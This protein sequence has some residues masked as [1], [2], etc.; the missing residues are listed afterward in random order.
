MPGDHFFFFFNI[1]VLDFCDRHTVLILINVPAPINVL[2]FFS[3]K[4]LY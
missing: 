3:E 4:L 2:C 1:H